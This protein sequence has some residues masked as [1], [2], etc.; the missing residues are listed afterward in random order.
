MNVVTYTGTASALTVSGLN[1]SPD[2]LWI[3]NRTLGT[4]GNHVVYDSV[5]GGPSNELYPNLTNAEAAAI[6]ALQSL[7]SNGFT[8]SNAGDLVR[9]NNNTNLY[10]AW[11]W[12]RS[13]IAGM[14]I[15][16][17]V[18]NDNSGRTIS[19]NLGVIP[20]MIIVKN[21]TTVSDWPVYHANLTASNVVFLQ[22]TNAQN[23]I[24][25]YA[26]GAVSSASSTTFTV[27]AGNTDIRNVNK[28]GDNYVAYCFSDVEGFSKFGSYSGNNSVDGPFVYCGFRPRF[29][30]VKRTD[31]GEEWTIND[32]ARSPFNASSMGLFP[33]GNFMEQANMTV[34][35]VSNG[36]K[37]R[38]NATVNGNASGGTYIFA[39][40][41]ESPFKYARAR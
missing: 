31:A 15:V 11:A 1:F 33:S 17:Y 18:G 34:D 7:N 23:A 16:G 5:R 36:F 24:S 25:T 37:L 13:I 32:I 29:I 14:D 28:S 27:I 20:K 41:A 40:F 12:S 8:L 22:L 10:V 9:Y 30:M 39:A 4:G 38:S 19:H 21:R 26:W 35:L 2:L 3:K 6:G